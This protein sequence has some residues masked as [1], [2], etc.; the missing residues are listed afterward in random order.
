MNIGITCYP[1]VG[2][3]G[4]IGT[5]L[6]KH[7]ARRGHEVH[8]ITSSHPVRLGR[9]F[10]DKI[11]F[12]EA[13]NLDYPVFKYPPYALSLAAK[14][15]E[16]CRKVPLDLLHVHY[17]IPH[18]ASACIARQMLRDQGLK[19][20][21]T[22]HGTD[23]TLVGSRPGFIPLTRFFIEE[24]DGVTAVSNHLRDVTQ[25]IFD[26]QKEIQVIY[27]F[28]DTELFKPADTPEKI[29]ANFA[30]PDHF[31]MVHMSNFRRSKEYSTPSG[32]STWSRN[33]YLQ[34]S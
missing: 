19:T 16:I 18:A 12:H 8:F 7:L 20:I 9:E 32:F 21:T 10:C 13:E 2:G 5:E 34:P 27:N 30:P 22:L 15:A 31:I 17:A 14:M 11:F 4:I 24:S 1:G 29:R 28:V 33:R 26:V 23:V 3:S 25:K 6:G